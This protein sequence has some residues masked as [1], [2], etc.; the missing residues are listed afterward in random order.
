MK[1]AF[2]YFCS[3]SFF[4]L[5]M[6]ENISWTH[7][8]LS[9]CIF[10]VIS[11]IRIFEDISNHKVCMFVNFYGSWVILIMTIYL[12]ISSALHSCMLFQKVCENIIFFFLIN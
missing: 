6:I 3:N 7:P 8:Y 1:F 11:G 4:L 10:F 2:I 5:A 12:E 9:R